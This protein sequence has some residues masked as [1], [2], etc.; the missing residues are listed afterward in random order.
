MT[1]A[2][3]QTSLQLAVGE[4]F[5]GEYS[6]M[7][8][9]LAGSALLAAL[10]TW[11]WLASRSGFAIGFG[12]TVLVSAAL[13]AGMAVSLLVRDKAL[14]STV[15]QGVSS[16]HGGQMVA[17]EVARLETVVSK[18]RYYRYGAAVLAALSLLGLIVTSRGWVHGVAAGLL[19]VVVAQVVIDHFSEHRA[20][21]YLARLSTPAYQR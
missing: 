13:L 1:L 21:L 2:E 6:E 18:Y 17:E 19:L 5:S 15:T 8:F 16:P 14:S 20:R 7:L 12:A 10:A 9:I 11:L 3:A 4:Y